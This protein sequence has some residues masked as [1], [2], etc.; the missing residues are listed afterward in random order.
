MLPKVID[1][2]EQIMTAHRGEVSCVVT[3]AKPLDRATEKELATALE[4]FLEPGQKLHL[5]L[6]V[7][8]DTL[9]CH[10]C[11]LSLSLCIN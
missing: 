4:G 3:T 7:S 6:K 10:F 9:K 8:F 2:F 5:S 1:T 11:S